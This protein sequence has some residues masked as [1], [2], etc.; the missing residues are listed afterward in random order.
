MLF[1]GH[2]R[3]FRGGVEALVAQVLLEQSQPITGIIQFH[4]VHRK[5]VPQAMRTGVMDSTSFMI[6][7][8]WQASSFSAFAHD[9]P[10][11]VT[12]YAKNRPFPIL[13]DPATK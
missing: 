11:P 9:L 2:F 8:F 10:G 6:L 1:P 7:Q 3:I 4:G 13:N 12:I 5:G